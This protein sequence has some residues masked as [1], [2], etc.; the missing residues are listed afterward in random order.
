MV[1]IITISKN[2]T[3]IIPKDV[4]QEAGIS[5]EQKYVLVTDSGDIILKRIG[6]DYNKAR[7][8]ELIKEFRAGFKKNKIKKTDIENVCKSARSQTA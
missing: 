8:L 6:N 2:G 4:R 7:M 5:D 1:K 3:L